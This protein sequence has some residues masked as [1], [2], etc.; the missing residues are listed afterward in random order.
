MDDRNESISSDYIS[1]NR[2][3]AQIELF[4][5]SLNLSREKWRPNWTWRGS[6][7]ALAT[8]NKDL[9]VNPLTH[10]P[11]PHGNS[12]RQSVFSW[13]SNAPKADTAWTSAI[14]HQNTKIWFIKS[15]FWQRPP[16]WKV[17]C[18]SKVSYQTFVRSI[19]DLGLVF[20]YWNNVTFRMLELS[21]VYEAEILR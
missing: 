16:C 13:F 11:I 2:C 21:K 17:M 14:V 3:T 6:A 8:V 4:I 9:P 10:R 18:V 19:L 12:C 20:W 15:L 1:I 7:T 5:D